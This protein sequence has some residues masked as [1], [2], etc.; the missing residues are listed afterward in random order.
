MIY[1]SRAKKYEVHDL[2]TYV[3][4]I[5]LYLIERGMALR[6]ARSVVTST[7]VRSRVRSMCLAETSS[8]ACAT[9]ERTEVVERL[10]SASMTFFAAEDKAVAVNE[11]AGGWYWPSE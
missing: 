6:T 11:K 4:R 3:T 9:V 1:N 10:A 7:R 8:T 5:F 2:V